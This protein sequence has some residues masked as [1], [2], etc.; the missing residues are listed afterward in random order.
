MHASYRSAVF[1]SGNSGY[2]AWAISREAETPR[3]LRRMNHKRMCDIGKPPK[4]QTRRK[5]QVHE[6][7][8]GYI[9]KSGSPVK[10]KIS[11]LRHCASDKK[12]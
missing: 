4:R 6:F 11:I 2:A 10:R 3:T 7:D 12:G 1:G 9:T 5:K 8:E